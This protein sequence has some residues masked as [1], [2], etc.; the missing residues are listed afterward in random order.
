M[1][2]YGAVNVQLHTSL[3]SSLDKCEWTAS[4]SGRLSS[5]ERVACTHLC[6]LKIGL[7]EVAET[8]KSFPCQ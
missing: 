2:A 1:K 3:N 7:D 5:S 8:W 4:H 6:D